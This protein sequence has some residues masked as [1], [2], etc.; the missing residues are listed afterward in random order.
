MTKKILSLAM[1]AMMGMSLNA[2][3]APQQKGADKKVAKKGVVQ[4]QNCCKK[5]GKCPQLTDSVKCCKGGPKQA[6]DG[7]GCKAGNCPVAYD[8]TTLNVT[9]DQQTKIDALNENMKATRQ[10]M[11]EQNI[12]AKDSVK[13][14]RRA[15]A[16]EAKKNYLGQLRT[17]L[18]ADQY[19]QF[20]EDNYVNQAPQGQKMGQK[21][22]QRPGKGQKDGKGQKQGQR[23]DFN[24]TDRGMKK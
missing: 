12:Q 6:K 13:A 2:V 9:P 16:K 20:L 11:R 19:V 3:A 22:G 15:K 4:Q 21:Q 8:F 14:D 17:I 24:K 18:T 1:I 5:D 10:Q 23:P 7:K